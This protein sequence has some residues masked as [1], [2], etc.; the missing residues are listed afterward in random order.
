MSATDSTP[1][2]PSEMLV[3]D[4]PYEVERWRPLVNWALYIP[5]AII[6]Y[7]L[8]AV[9]SAAWFINWVILIFTGRLNASLYGFMAMYERYNQ[10][11]GGFLVGF[12][13]DYAP[14]DFGMGPADNQ[15]YPPVRVTFPVAPEATPRTA[16]FNFLLAIPHY[17]V[18]ALIGIGAFFVLLAGWFAVIVTGAWPQGLR[19][20]LVR[21]GNYYLRVWTYAAMVDTTYPR[22]GL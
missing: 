3:V 5:H 2:V 10:R 16:A 11:A 14:F 19:D 8:G 20:F 4:S 22:F 15:A 17:I 18:I 1:A 9:A 7:P 12:S 6:L 21:F 13:N